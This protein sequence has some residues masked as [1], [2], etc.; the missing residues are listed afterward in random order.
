VRPIRCG[1]FI[2]KGAGIFENRIVPN[3]TKVPAIFKVVFIVSLVVGIKADFCP[4][5]MAPYMKSS[6]FSALH[7]EAYFH[8]A[9]LE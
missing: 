2:A 6:F 9:H 5:D 4:N 7:H 8:R 3:E 1:V